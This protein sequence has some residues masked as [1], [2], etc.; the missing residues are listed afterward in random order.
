MLILS[1]VCVSVNT[2][3]AAVSDASSALQ[4]IQDNIK[5]VTGTQPQIVVKE[6]G[7]REVM[8]PW[9]N[10]AVGTV[11]WQTY[12]VETQNDGT[13]VYTTGNS[14]GSVN[15]ITC[16]KDACTGW[17]TPE[18]NASFGAVNS[19]PEK[20]LIYTTE[21]IPGGNCVCV[22]GCWGSTG[23]LTKKKYQCEVTK[24]FSSFQ[25]MLATIIKWFIYV[26]ILVSV[27][28]LVGLGIAW[29]LAGGDDIKAK[30]GLKKWAINIMI[31]FVILIFFTTILRFIAPWIFM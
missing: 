15:T 2:W 8:I 31:G 4:G 24:W 12:T 20:V 27:L 28:A 19:S 30:T 21:D 11:W 29:S 13:K 5:N 25:S 17:S 26:A 23:D 22:D 18:Q 6:N 10:R 3:F 16:N 7:A 14:D 9:S 1:S